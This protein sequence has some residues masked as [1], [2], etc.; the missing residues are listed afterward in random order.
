MS[1]AELLWVDHLGLYVKAASQEGVV[2]T[3]RVPFLRSV[4]DDRDARSVL[5]M[6]AQVGGDVCWCGQH[7]S[8]VGV[9]GSVC[10]GG[11]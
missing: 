6:M 5:T 10:W 11:L 4:E 8:I 7:A 2:R 9:A 3:L 1:Y